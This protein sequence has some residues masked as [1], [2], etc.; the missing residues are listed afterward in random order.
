MDLEGDGEEERLT[1]PDVDVFTPATSHGQDW[2]AVATPDEDGF[3]C[4]SIALC[5]SPA[6][7]HTMLHCAGRRCCLG[8]KG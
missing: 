7:R 5:W 2:V 3:R 4:R 1:P 6:L 8:M